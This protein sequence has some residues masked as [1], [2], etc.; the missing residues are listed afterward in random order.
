MIENAHFIFI[1]IGLGKFEDNK[2]FVD[3]FNIFKNLNPDIETILWDEKKI[4]ELI[5]KHYK[6]LKKF[7]N[8]LPLFYRIDFSRYLILKYI[9]EYILI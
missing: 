2:L 1:E 3:N 5:N 8:E 6:H 4:K 9:E 7:Y